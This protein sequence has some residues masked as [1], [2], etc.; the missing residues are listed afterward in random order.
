MDFKLFLSFD[1]AG[2]GAFDK[3]AVI[4]LINDFSS[5]SSY[6]HYKSKPL[7]S[8]FEGPD[9]A[10]DWVSIKEQTGCFF[11]PDWSSLGAKA[12]LETGVVDGLF[13]WA[14]W[15]WG[16]TDMDTYVDASYLDCWV[17]TEPI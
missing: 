1:Y 3:D 6:F 15:P 8:T 10:A 4:S 9:S 7:V 14:A 11:I 5:S 13:N 2:N 12:A 16:N 17:K